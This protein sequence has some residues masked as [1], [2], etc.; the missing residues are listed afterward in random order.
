[1]VTDPDGRRFTVVDTEAKSDPMRSIT[2]ACTDLKATT[3]SFSYQMF[4]K[5]YHADYWTSICGLT[6]LNS[7]NAE[8]RLQMG[9]DGCVL[10]FVK[11][12]SV[13]AGSGFGR[14]AFSCA[15]AELPDI[16]AK[17]KAK[18]TTVLTPLVSLDTPGK[19]FVI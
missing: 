15:A 4:E 19:L 7:N 12:D 2:L 14:I 11:R 8:A 3:G 18:G 10:A 9:N 16:E 6:L 5:A 1:M 13:A 17:A